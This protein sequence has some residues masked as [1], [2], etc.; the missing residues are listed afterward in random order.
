MDPANVLGLKL[1]LSIAA[2]KDSKLPFNQVNYQSGE[3]HTEEEKLSPPYSRFPCSGKS[4]PGLRNCEGGHEAVF[5]ILACLFSLFFFLFRYSSQSSAKIQT[6]LPASQPLGFRLDHR[7]CTFAG[8]WTW[9]S[10]L[11]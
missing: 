4:W 11:L 7:W 1:P 5:P 8:W 2:L 10:F 9:Q 3:K 6:G